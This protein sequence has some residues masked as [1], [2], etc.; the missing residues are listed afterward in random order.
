MQRYASLLNSL[1]K[2]GLSKS[3]LQNKLAVVD[4]TLG[5]E[6]HLELLIA[7]GLPIIKVGDMYELQT[8]FTK[9]ED[10]TFCVVDIE[11]NGSKVPRG[12]IIEIGAIKY[13][14]G[15]IIDEF[16][17]LVFAKVV[18]EYVTK[19]TNI[20]QRDLIDAPTNEEVL[21]KFKI[22][23]DDHV[24]VAHNASFDYNFISTWFEKIGLFGMLNRSFCTIDLAKK[25]INAEKF[26]LK[27]LKEHLDI[28]IL[29]HRALEDAISTTKILEHSFENLPD[30]VKT[31]ENLIDFTHS[32][33]IK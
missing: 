10:E 11:T 22:F 33:N 13:K 26:G 30:N 24:F 14:N 29:H 5:F 19:I 27:S 6:T 7:S 25:T 20:R 2:T 1:K 15:E 23:L 8:K 9:V 28:D 18:P 12:Q 3:G 32:I 4:I 16:H 31:T 17:S 21:K